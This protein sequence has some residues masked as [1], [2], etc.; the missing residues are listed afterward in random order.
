MMNFSFGPPA[1]SPNSRG[2]FA[3]PLFE[4]NP[5]LPDS[6]AMLCRQPTLPKL[7]VVTAPPG[8]GKTVFM[9]VLH[10]RQAEWKHRI[11]WVTLDDRDRSVASIVALLRAA[12][13]QTSDAQVSSLTHSPD[14]LATSDASV[15]TLFS[16]IEALLGT[17]V[18]FI[19][20]AH[21]CDD[22]QLG[23]FLDEL[24]FGTSA[25]LRLVISSTNALPM[26]LVRAK[27]E[28]SAQVISAEHL[29]FDR[30]TVERLF[31]EGDRPLLSPNLAESIVARTEGWPAA[32]RLLLVLAQH[33]GMCIEQAIERFSGE[34]ADIA[35]VLTRRVLAGFSLEMV[36]FLC[37]IALLR[38][39]SAELATC[40]TG[41]PEAGEWIAMLMQRNLLIFPLDSSRRWLRMHTLLRQ[42]LLSEGRRRISRDRRKSLLER[43]AK[44]H[45]EQGDDAAA[46][47]LALIA[48]NYL[49]ASAALSRSGRVLVG[50]LGQLPRFMLWVEQLMA[51]GAPLSLDTHAW[52]IWALCF[53]LKYEAAQRSIEAFDARLAVQDLPVERAATYR[54]RLGLL[55]VVVG[56]Y[57]DQLDFARSSAAQWLTNESSQDALSIATVATGAAVADLAACDILA[58]R[59]HMELATSAVS[60]TDSLYG[61]AWVASI[62]ACIELAQGNP[63]EADRLIARSRPP[64]IGGLGTDASVVA[65]LDF[66]HARALADLGRRCD[67]QVAARRGLARASQH[68]VTETTRQG[69]AACISFWEGEDEGPWTPSELEPVVRSHGERMGLLF[70]A[71]MVCRLVQLS[72]LEDA[73]CMAERLEL[74]GLHEVVLPRREIEASELA[75]AR[76][77]VAV[78]NGRYREAMKW[79]M[80][81]LT[82]A[83]SLGMH[84]ELVELRLLATDACV[85][86][87]DSRRALQQL[88]AAIVHAARRRLTGPFK[89]HREAVGRVL[90]SQPDRAFGFVLP[91]E[92]AFLARL[93]DG[94]DTAG[95][96]T[97]E[98][99]VPA[100]T[101]LTEPLT[102]RELQF[103][104]LLAAG[105]NNQQVAD[106]EGL[107]VQTVKWH[108][109]N[110][111]GKLSVKNRVA[112]VAAARALGVVR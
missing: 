74:I 21:F 5:V 101:G 73:N 80:A 3:P 68:G 90:H 104:T 69:I 105:W 45:G 36:Q 40:M 85:R 81:R 53:S 28:V 51:A 52:Y 17:I 1:G 32:V 34:H 25:S 87:G 82:L 27:L 72:R 86:Q 89:D 46:I 92:R 55:R 13:A 12:I 8:Y 78:A 18:L 59:R 66:V 71:M 57:L 95:L 64:I 108:L 7:L 26:D 16:E 88:S 110:L 39:F 38:E 84:R 48:P 61:Q 49:Q 93:R 67:A 97:A 58:A 22:E 23:A 2:R 43:A 106:R 98:S 14:A 56:I 4:F 54:R 15:S 70:D 63:V 99:S 83:H 107:S 44:W 100:V 20:N 50:R 10:R 24:T 29:C 112:A 94:S 41:V 102:P 42:Y 37:E 11:L 9:S 76:I 31:R 91:D 96:A 77:H 60:R 79:I 33:S 30:Q 75:L 6:V 111:Y 109:Y 35:A 19:D 103:L 65:T 47:D 62:R